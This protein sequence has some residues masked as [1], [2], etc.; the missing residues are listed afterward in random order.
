MVVAKLPSSSQEGHLSSAI[1]AS[2]GEDILTNVPD[3][4]VHTMIEA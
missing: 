4:R 1:A 2:P 3:I